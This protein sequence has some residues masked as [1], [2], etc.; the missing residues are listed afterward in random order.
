MQ[1]FHRFA[2][3]PPFEIALFGIDLL[4]TEAFALSVDVY[5]ALQKG[6]GET[7]GC[8]ARCQSLGNHET[9]SELIQVVSEW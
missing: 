8:N 7:R 3:H 6:Q 5:T 9:S 4:G 2:L 1:D